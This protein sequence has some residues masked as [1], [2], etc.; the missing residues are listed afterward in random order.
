MYSPYTTHEKYRVRTFTAQPEFRYWFDRLNYKHF[1]GVHGIV[2]LFNVSAGESLRYQTM[3]D[4]NGN[5][6]PLLGVG[7]SYGYAWFLDKKE[8]WCME[9]TVGVGYAYIQYDKFYN[10]E[11]GKCF[12]NGVFHYGGLTKLGLNIAYRFDTTKQPKNK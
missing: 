3:R 8:H 4:E 1:I 9:F 7:L 11:N 2:T 10:V 6:H 12:D 5:Y